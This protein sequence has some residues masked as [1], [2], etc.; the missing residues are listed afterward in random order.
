MSLYHLHRYS[1][2]RHNPVVQ[3]KTHLPS[4]KDI[5]LQCTSMHNFEHNQ[6]STI[7]LN[8]ITTTL[9]II[10]LFNKYVRDVKK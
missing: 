9:K 1:R 5:V 8:F 6:R 3:F 7:A 10:K 2:Q 4:C